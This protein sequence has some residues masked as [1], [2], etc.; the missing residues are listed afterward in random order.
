MFR[1]IRWLAYGFFAYYIYD[2]VTSID[3]KKPAP[4]APAAA[5]H[6]ANRSSTLTGQTGQG[7]AVPVE[8]ASGAHRT[9]RVGRGVVSQ[10]AV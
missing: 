8:D 10:R 6:A 1:L 2:V 7:M 4:N 9:T 5:P 3:R